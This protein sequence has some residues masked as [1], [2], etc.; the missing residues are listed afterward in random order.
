MEAFIMV[1]VLASPLAGILTAI[2]QSAVGGVIGL[3]AAVA[4]GVLYYALNKRM[5]IGLVEMSGVVNQIVFKRSVL[6]GIKLDEQSSAHASD[7]IQWLMD[8]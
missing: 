6:E 3:L 4:C 8:G 2:M 1:V 7:I 5:T